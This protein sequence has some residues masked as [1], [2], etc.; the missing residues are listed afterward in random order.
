MHPLRTEGQGLPG[1]AAKAY[2]LT[3]VALSIQGGIFIRISEKFYFDIELT[4]YFTSTDYLDDV[5][6]VYYDNDLL[7]QYR[8][9]LAARLADRHTEL[10]PPGSPNFSAGTPRGN[11]TKND[12]FAYLKFGISIA[13]DRKQGQVRNSNVKCPQISKDWFEK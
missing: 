1:S 12:Q 2:S 8:G 7:R 3:Q 4:Q 10:L 5:S 6:G 9:D 13:L 11:P